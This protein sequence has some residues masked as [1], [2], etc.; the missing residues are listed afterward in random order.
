M[1][2]HGIC[3]V[4]N[5]KLVKTN[6]SIF[7]SHAH[8]Q[9][10]ERIGGTPKIDQLPV[11]FAHELMKMQPGL[12]LER[13]C[14]KKTIHQKAFTPANAAVQIDPKRNVRMVDQLLDRVGALLPEPGPV[15]RAALQSRDLS[16]IH[17]SE[18]TRLGMLS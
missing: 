8:R 6:Q 5:V 4:S 1:Q 17:I 15:P 2:N 14:A 7:F 16:L 11:N 18:P 3:D 12:A 13:Q 9:H 10:I